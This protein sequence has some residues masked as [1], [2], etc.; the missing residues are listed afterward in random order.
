MA[1][2]IV[3]VQYTRKGME[4]IKQRPA[5]LDTAKNAFK[6][7]GAELKEF[8]MV[9]GHYDMV[10]IAEAPDYE[11]VSKIAR[12]I[13]PQDIVNTETIS[14]FTEEEYKKIISGLP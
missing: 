13:G 3:L 2:Y 12:S 9:S 5:C 8:F 7:M 6:E 4:N 14:A 11:T 10:V 1:T